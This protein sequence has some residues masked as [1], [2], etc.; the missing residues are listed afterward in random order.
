MHPCATTVL[1]WTRGYGVLYCTLVT[2]LLDGAA[3]PEDLFAACT[4]QNL[5]PCCWPLGFTYLWVT[6]PSSWENYCLSSENLSKQ[7]TSTVTA[8]EKRV[9]NMF[10][11]LRK[12]TASASIIQ[13]Q[14]DNI[15]QKKNKFLNVSGTS[16]KPTW[17]LDQLFQ[18]CSCRLGWQYSTA[19]YPHNTAFG[20]QM[21]HKARQPGRWGLWWRVRFRMTSSSWSKWV[22]QAVKT[23]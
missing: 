13:W 1:S 20:G 23:Q 21:F 5:Q 11:F 10:P 3:L 22:K 8:S 15:E 17:F 9:R 16:V 14:M 2:P 18:I 6:Y 4:F 7:N 19:E 12:V